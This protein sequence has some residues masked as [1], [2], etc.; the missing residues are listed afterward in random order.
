[1]RSVEPLI[2]RGVPDFVGI[3]AAI[4]SIALNVNHV[5]CPPRDM[6][7]QAPMLPLQAPKPTFHVE[8]RETSI[9]NQGWLHITVTEM[10]PS[11]SRDG[12][13]RQRTATALIKQPALALSPCNALTRESGEQL[14]L[15]G[16]PAPR[17][18]TRRP[19]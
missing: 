7:P 15:G 11:P 6:R 4:T 19:G 17:G 3:N 14:P 12:L 2:L 16:R 9:T 1:M 5:Q 8:P 13:A 18:L 10:S